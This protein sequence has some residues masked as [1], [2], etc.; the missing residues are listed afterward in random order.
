[1]WQTPGQRRITGIR[2]L[3]LAVGLLICK[4]VVGIIWNCRYY[5]PPDFSSDFLRGRQSYF[6]NGYHVAFFAHIVSGPCAMIL[7]LILLSD[8]VRRRWPRWH[9]VLG[10]IQ[11]ACVLLIVAPSGLWM[12]SRAETGAVAGFGFA[13]L[14]IATG[15]TVAM[16]WRAAVRRRF[17][18]HRIWMLRCFLLLSSAVVLR[19]MAGLATVLSI[20]GDCIYPASAWLSWLLPLAAFEVR[21]VVFNE[22][23]A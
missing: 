21:R 8:T 9:R 7:G 16:G 3:Q 10:R 2:L 15:T 17:G 12:S 18:V 23:R 22:P 14:A 19:L 5:F 4:V 11:V 20:E 1:M 6:F 13:A